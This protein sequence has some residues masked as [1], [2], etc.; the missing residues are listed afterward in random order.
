MMYRIVKILM[1]ILF[2]LIINQ[3][4]SVERIII[5]DK[6]KPKTISDIYNKT[7]FDS[8]SLLSN[9]KKTYTWSGE[10]CGKNNIISAFNKQITENEEYLCEISEDTS[11]GNTEISKN[12][13]IKLRNLEIGSCDIT[14]WEFDGNIYKR[15]YTKVLD[16]SNYEYT[17]NYKE[18]KDYEH[19]IDCQN[20]VLI[21]APGYFDNLRYNDIKSDSPIIRNI[22]LTEYFESWEFDLISFKEEV[23]ERSGCKNITTSL[24]NT[25][26]FS[27]DADNYVKFAGY[28]WRIIRLNE[29]GTIRMILDGDIGNTNWN[30]SGK[31]EID[32]GYTYEDGKKSNVKKLLDEWYNDVLKEK[33]YMGY[34]K[35]GKFCNDTNSKSSALFECEGPFK[36]GGKYEEYIGLITADELKAGN[37]NLSYNNNSYLSYKKPFWTMTQSSYKSNMVASSICSLENDF[38]I[39]NCLKDEKITDIQASYYH[40]YEESLYQGDRSISVRPVINID[41]NAYVHNTD[42][43]TKGSPYI[44]VDN[45]EIIYIFKNNS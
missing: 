41:G 21:D 37:S 5:I 40:D 38:E 17:I 13:T 23:A 33:D 6:F 35:K 18:G 20:Y 31:S 39:T 22:Y 28:M 16:S 19:V 10:S 2:I 43:G 8:F 32:G 25:C 44:V 9:S 29:D 36:Y 24:G 12:V 3:Y 1:I 7:Y 42:M 34:I 27:G 14:V 15:V 11:G 26:Y 4:I 45:P 30:N